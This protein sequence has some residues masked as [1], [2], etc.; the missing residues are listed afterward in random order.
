MM[1]VLSDPA[2]VRVGA[3]TAHALVG[4]DDE[5]AE[6]VPLLTLATPHIGHFQIRTRGTLGGA[7][8]QV[9]AETDGDGYSIH[10]EGRTSP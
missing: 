3:G 5:V 1:A 9:A 6:S 8:A 7:I 10:R 2:E 4:M